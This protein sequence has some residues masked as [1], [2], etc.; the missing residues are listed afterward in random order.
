MK[1]DSMVAHALLEV[2]STAGHQG[3]DVHA[4][5]LLVDTA[6]GEH[7]IQAIQGRGGPSLCCVLVALLR[8]V[9]G[10]NPQLGRLVQGELAAILDG[11]PPAAAGL[12]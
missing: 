2:V 7:S 4:A 12:H 10:E 11:G 3:R 9:V 8:R 1:I 5:L 6:S